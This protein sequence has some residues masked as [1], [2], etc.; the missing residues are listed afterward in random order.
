[1]NRRGSDHTKWWTSAQRLLLLVSLSTSKCTTTHAHLPRGNPHQWNGLEWWNFLSIWLVLMTLELL[2][3]VTGFNIF[4]ML[5]P[6]LRSVE[7]KECGWNDIKTQFK[8]KESNSEGNFCTSLFN[9]R[10]WRWIGKNTWNLFRGLLTSNWVLNYF[11]FS[12]GTRR[13]KIF[14]QLSKIAYIYFCFEE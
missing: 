4:S 11:M 12:Y 1:M 8:T 3:Y 9:A 14:V 2:D 6:K 13:K 10:H 7:W 5:F